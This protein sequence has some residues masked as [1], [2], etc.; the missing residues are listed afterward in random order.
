MVVGP[1]DVSDIRPTFSAE[2]KPG[3]R[4]II[5]ATPRGWRV[6]ARHEPCYRTVDVNDPMDLMLFYEIHQCPVKE[7]PDDYDL[8]PG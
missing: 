7:A 5:S 3:F 6:I 4:L 2:H 1:L 8:Q